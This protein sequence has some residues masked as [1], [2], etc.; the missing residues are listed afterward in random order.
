MVSKLDL[1]IE[2]G[3]EA[4]VDSRLKLTELKKKI[5]K[6]IEDYFE[7]NKDVYEYDVWSNEFNSDYEK[8]DVDN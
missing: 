3:I 4:T 7:K 5:V 2:I 8:V 1:N 6:E